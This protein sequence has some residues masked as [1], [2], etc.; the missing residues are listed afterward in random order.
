MRWAI[1]GTPGTGKSTAAAQL[2][3]DLPIVH[4][5]E[6]IET[7][8]Y[9][10]GYDDERGTA[11]ADLDAIVDWLDDQPASIVV[12]S[13][14][15]HR[16]PVDGVIVLRCHP[17]ELADRLRE[18]GESTESIRENVD[19]ERLDVILVDALELHGDEAIYEID[20][21]GRSPRTVADEIERVIAGEREPGA[22]RVS[23]LEDT[24]R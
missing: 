20:T 14:L 6:L 15:A 7:A 1:S 17:D 18:R 23:F 13:H 22:G 16:L 2:T 19:S 9:T 8:G 5:N 12:E 21:T 4:L 3:V 24:D 11:I 10:T